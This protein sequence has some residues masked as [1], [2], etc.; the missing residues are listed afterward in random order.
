MINTYYSKRLLG[1]Q[2][3]LY[4]INFNNNIKKLL[5]SHFDLKNEKYLVIFERHGA[6]QHKI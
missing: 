4:V 6:V 2:Y 5:L 1:Y 3:V